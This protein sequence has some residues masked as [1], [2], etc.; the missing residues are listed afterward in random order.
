[1]T[2]EWGRR[3]SARMFVSV[4]MLAVGWGGEV[5]VAAAQTANSPT[6]GMPLPSLGQVTTTDPYHVLDPN[7]ISGFTEGAD[8]GAEGEKSIEFETTTA[9]GLRG[10]TYA[11]LEQGVEF[12]GV[13]PQ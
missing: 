1:M 3:F 8:I 6:S 4:S 7:Y 5:S 12:E 9:S 11:A 13:P 2:I 10:G